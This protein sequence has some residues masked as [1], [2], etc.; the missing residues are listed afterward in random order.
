MLSEAPVTEIHEIF[1]SYQ[2]E[3][4]RVGE[5]TIFVRFARCDLACR[6]CD[7]PP[8]ERP[9]RMT[10]EE[11]LVHVRQLETRNGPHTFVS[12]TGGEPL[13]YASFL[14]VFLPRLKQ[15]GFRTYLESD[16]TK[17]RELGEVVDWIDLIAMDIKL[18]SATGMR[19]FW[20]EHEAYLETGRRTGIFIKAVVA[21]STPPEEVEHAARLTARY[22]PDAPFIIQPASAFGAFQD[23][24]GEE[25]ISRLVRA[26]RTHLADV[27]V[28]GQT[29][30]LIGVR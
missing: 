29:H 28:I 3:G 15:E 27:R 20:T 18:P 1:S 10:V 12:L 22:V 2:G 23:I 25:T 8:P 5:P 24:P 7:T 17:P 14:K 6:Y 21:D 26:A 13:R 9:I 30:K 19:P 11:V 16:G 4:I